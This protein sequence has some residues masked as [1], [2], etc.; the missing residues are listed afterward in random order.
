MIIILLNNICSSSPLTHNNKNLKIGF[1][2]KLKTIIC[3]PHYYSSD[4]Y[5]Y[6]IF[7]NNCG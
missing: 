6:I 5:Y 1:D 4:F 3:H 2:S 7:P